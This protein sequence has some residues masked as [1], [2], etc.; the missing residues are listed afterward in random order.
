MAR[1]STI[2]RQETPTMPAATQS[3]FTKVYEALGNE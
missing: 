2:T 3:C 1:L